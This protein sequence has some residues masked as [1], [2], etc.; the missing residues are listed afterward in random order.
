MF[1]YTVRA[2]TVHDAL[3]LSNLRQLVDKETDHLDREEGEQVLSEAQFREILI[4]DHEEEN[5]YCVVAEHNQ[6]LVGFA[7]L[8]GSN[9]KRF[10]HHVEFGAAIQKSHWGKRLGTRL[11]QDCLSYADDHQLAKVTLR[12]QE[13][14]Y[15]ALQLYKNYDFVIEGTLNDDKRMPDGTLQHTVLMARFLT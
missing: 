6:Q 15:K 2:A 10:Q 9:L 5:R 1:D 11:L 14:N 13:S 4:K 8:Q 12:V 3:Q 7:R